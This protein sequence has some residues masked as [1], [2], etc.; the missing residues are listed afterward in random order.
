MIG[1][2]LIVLGIAIFIPV[3]ILF[4]GSVW[5]GGPRGIRAAAAG[6]LLLVIPVGMVFHGILVLCGIH[7]RDFYS[8][9]DNL[10]GPVRGLAWC[11][12]A[13]LILIFVIVGF[14]GEAFGPT[15]T[16]FDDD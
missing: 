3:A 2:L 5:M 8:W 12:L 14:F 11:L 4:I 10:G 1:V 6:I 15:N 9:W 13:L 16:K 7:P